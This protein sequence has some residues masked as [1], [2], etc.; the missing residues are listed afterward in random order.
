LVGEL[1]ARALVEDDVEERSILRHR[2]ELNCI[3]PV[4]LTRMFGS[5]A[6]R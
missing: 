4:M 1:P 3:E 5:R 2:N 6:S